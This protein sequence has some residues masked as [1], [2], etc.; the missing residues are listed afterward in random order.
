MPLRLF[1]RCFLVVF[2][3]KHKNSLSGFDEDG[4]LPKNKVD[5]SFMFCYDWHKVIGDSCFI[6][7]KS[8]VV[9]EGYSKYFIRV[10]NCNNNQ[11]KE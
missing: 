2:D 11:Y 10:D 6:V 8:S 3:K 5:E 7:R 1:L 9:K 4:I